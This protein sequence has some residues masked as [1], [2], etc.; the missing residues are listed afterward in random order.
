MPRSKPAVVVSLSAALLLATAGV[1]A[2]KV[3]IETNVDPEADFSAVR[4]YAWLPPAPVI[5]AVAPDI[6]TNPT[7][8][9]EALGPHIV[10]AVDRH[11][12]ARGLT[13]AGPDEADV[14]MVYFAA[15]TVGFSQSY[16][17]EHYGYVTGW[18]APIPLGFAPST[19]VSA[20]EKG[21]VLIDM[22]QRTAK[23]G[24]W[25]GTAVTRIDQEKT[26]EQRVKRINQAVDRMFEKFPIRQKR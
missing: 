14:H 16:L 8:S 7:L 3:K 9:Q 24:I 17:G 1:G 25:R 11:L 10:A 22:I 18:S 13:P 19:S 5:Q 20:Y 15:M 6:P 4:T 12:K 21:T 26:V 23:R 2:Q